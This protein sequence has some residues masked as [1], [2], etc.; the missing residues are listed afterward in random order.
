[1]KRARVVRKEKHAMQPD[2]RFVASVDA[3]GNLTIRTTENDPNFATDRAR[4][5]M[6]LQTALDSF[7]A[8]GMT[9]PVMFTCVDRGEK[10][11]QNWQLLKPTLMEAGTSTF[12]SAEDGSRHYIVTVDVARKVLFA[13]CGKSASR[14]FRVPHF[15]LGYWTVNIGSEGMQVLE[16]RTF[17][18]IAV[19]EGK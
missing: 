1:M 14:L 11:A 10:A 15:S 2:P 16:S 9:H 17:K 3:A 18:D 13:L 8:R 4:E 6:E 5:E 19:T 7:R 12:S